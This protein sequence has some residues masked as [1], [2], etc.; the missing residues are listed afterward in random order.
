MFIFWSASETF[1]QML[2]GY[3]LTLTS[4]FHVVFLLCQ[5]DRIWLLNIYLEFFENLNFLLVCGS[6]FIQFKIS[7]LIVWGG[8]SK[9]YLELELE[10]LYLGTL[11]RWLP[12]VFRRICSRKEYLF[13]DKLCI[14]II[15]QV[16]LI[17][18][19]ESSGF[20]LPYI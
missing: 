20:N 9:H 17:K 19:P 15:I 1:L 6:I 10:F 12:C 3:H 13:I 11:F 7:T 2:L 18:D 4:L 5:L 14:M 16:Y 8:L